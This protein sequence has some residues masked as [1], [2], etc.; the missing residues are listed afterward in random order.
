[1]YDL[2]T[3]RR[4]IT[5]HEGGSSFSEVSRLT[6]VSRFTIRQW[7]VS[8]PAQ[9]R[10]VAACPLKGGD[11][12]RQIHRD[13]YAYL[14]GLYL[15]DGCI[16]KAARGV[17]ALRVA[18]CDG[19]PGLTDLCDATMRAVMP[20]NSVCRVQAVG[21]SQVVSYSKHWPCLFPQHGPG[22][23]HDRSIVLVPWQRRIVEQYPWE[24][25]RGLIHSDG[26]RITNWTTKRI[27]G[28]VKRYE[29]PRYFFTNMSRDIV[30]LYT[31]T[32]DRVGVAWTASQRRTG[33]VNVSVAQRESVALMDQYI[34][35]KY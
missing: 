33:A 14:L 20:R 18:C 17:Y 29:Y 2:D 30:D 28:A 34:G 32:L 4:A 31:G 19:W 21:C 7:V 16:S 27:G 24:L 15:G 9:P 13:D 1:M 25:I 8:T 3:R 11:L 23:K 22:K 6:G 35:P 5:L 10:K 26:C 12:H